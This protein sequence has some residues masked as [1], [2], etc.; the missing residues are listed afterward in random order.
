MKGRGDLFSE[1]R[2]ALPHSIERPFGLELR[3]ERQLG[4]EILH[5]TAPEENLRCNGNLLCLRSVPEH[6]PGG[7][8]QAV[9]NLCCGLQK[10]DPHGPIPT[11]S[12]LVVFSKS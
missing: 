5:S 2:K 8:R 7:V 11:R 1:G 4:P 3:A 10:R 9:K 12:E 6:G